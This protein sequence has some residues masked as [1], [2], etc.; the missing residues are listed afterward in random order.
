M[1]KKKPIGSNAR[2]WNG[3]NIQFY[4]NKNGLFS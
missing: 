4:K 3:K 2:K 1:I